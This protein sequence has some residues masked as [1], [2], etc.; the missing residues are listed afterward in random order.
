MRIALLLTL[1]ALPAIGQDA[2]KSF[3][4]Q[5]DQLSRV[6][7]ELLAPPTIQDAIGLA[8]EEMKTLNEVAAACVKALPTTAGLVFEARMRAI[9]SGDLAESSEW[10]AKRMKETE[11]RAAAIVARH[12]EKLKA[13][14][15]EAAFQ[16]IETFIQ[17]DGLRH[18]FACAPGTIVEI[19]R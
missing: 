19:R 17:S 15:G 14:L 12:V 8:S 18:C 13:A 11:E 5:V 10:L 2:Y 7:A 4:L 1:C 6:K 3:F 9:D 16:K